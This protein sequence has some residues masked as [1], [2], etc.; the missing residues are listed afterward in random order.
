MIAQSFADFVKE[1]AIFLP[2]IDEKNDS[3][4]QKM[5][6]YQCI[7]IGEMHGTQE[8]ALFAIG[9][10]K[11]LSQKKK[12]VLGIEI[13]ANDMLGFKPKK[14]KHT[15]LKTKFFR[16]GYNDGR[17]NEAWFQLIVEASKM[18]NVTICFFDNHEKQR[19]SMMYENLKTAYRKDTSQI[20]VTLSGNIHNI[21][22]PFRGEK[23]MGVYFL[24]DFPKE[25]I[26]AIN[27]EYDGGTMY[28][29]MGDGLKI[30]TIEP[31]NSFLAKASKANHYLLTKMPEGFSQNHNMLLFCREVH[32]A[33][34]K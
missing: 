19:D 10:L 27:V 18:K 29:N 2:K 15:L 13:P 33:K 9:V 30:R 5:L 28:N 11:S 24:A 7:M 3:L 25:K 8:P 16:E 17:K 4:A 14:A 12:I 26:A 1:N 23:K 32:A 31:K 22:L 6:D 21:L 34:P 20:I